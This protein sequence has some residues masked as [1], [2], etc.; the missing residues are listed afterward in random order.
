MRG[1]LC[2][3]FSVV[4]AYFVTSPIAR[5]RVQGFDLA[6]A[7]DVPGV[8]DIMT[9]ENT[10]GQ[11]K[12]PGFFAAGGYASTTMR[13]LDGPEIFQDGQIVA[14]VLAESYEAAREAAYKAGVS[15]RAESPAATFGSPGVKTEPAAEASKGHED[16]SVGDVEA[17]S[18]GRLGNGRR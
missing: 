9:Y 1:I 12:Q 3:R 16:P 6:A 17:G 4:Y 5:G 2:L 7:R 11:V 10:R 18:I 13:P 8:L 14:V 15:Y